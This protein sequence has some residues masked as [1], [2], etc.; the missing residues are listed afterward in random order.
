MSE[1]V[2]TDAMI[3][4]GANAVLEA[5]AYSANDRESA[6]AIYSAMLAAAPA[7]SAAPAQAPG[8]E[9]VVRSGIAQI[10]NRCIRP[11][12]RAEIREMCAALLEPRP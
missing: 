10:A 6:R 1:Y 11:V 8:R 3:D 12:S 4:V 9:E 2:I 7:L 5:R